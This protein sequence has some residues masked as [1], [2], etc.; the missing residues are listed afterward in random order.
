MKNQ[1]S[2]YSQ[3]NLVGTVETVGEKIEEY[4]EAGVTTFSALLFATNTLVGFLEM[5][6]QFAEEIIPA[7]K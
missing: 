2:N 5:M 1:D 6:Q 4:L 7:F 3:R